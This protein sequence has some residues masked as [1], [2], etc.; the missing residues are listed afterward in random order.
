MGS[1]RGASVFDHL[2]PAR[3][4]IGID[5]IN[6]HSH[7]FLNKSRELAIASVPDFVRVGRNSDFR[8]DLINPDSVVNPTRPVTDHFARD[9]EWSFPA[10]WTGVRS[11]EV[12]LCHAVARKGS[13]VTRFL[14]F[15][16]RAGSAPLP[17]FQQIY[18]REAT[19]NLMSE[20][21]RLSR[22]LRVT[23]PIALVVQAAIILHGLNELLQY[24]F[25]TM[26]KERKQDLDR[27]Q[28]MIL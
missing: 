6:A 16:P 15:I 3:Q 22:I 21:S 14:G 28:K 26:P 1:V 8:V 25:A 27:L 20:E 7:A 10:Q 24:D 11:N 4:L 9:V 12:I 23:T 19:H 17:A 13:L 18:Q 5:N 2:I